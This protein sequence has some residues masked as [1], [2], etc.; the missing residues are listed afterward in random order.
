MRTSVSRNAIVRL[1]ALFFA[2][3]PFFHILSAE[4]PAG[5]T[6]Y[7]QL[8]EWADEAVAKSDWERA[9]TCLQEAMRTEP[10][11]PLNIMLLSNMGM[12]QYYAGE[13]SLALRTLSEARAIAPASTVILTNRARVLTGMGR[14]DD[15]MRDY[16]MVLEMDSTCAD[17]YADR[18]SL[19]TAL[20]R[21]SEAEKDAVKFRSLRPDDPHGA[22]LL[23][24][25][26]SNTNRAA[27]A[28]PL[29]TELIN[30]KP[31]AVYYSARAMCRMLGGEFFEAADD[32][33]RGLELDPED[34][35]L[36][37]SRAY[38]N[39]LRFRDVDRDADAKRAV[40]LGIDPA[41]VKALPSL[42][43]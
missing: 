30:A 42:P 4:E 19:L 31:E 34:G 1:T 35:E 36:Y 3:V 41:R 39:H 27:D 25:I 17:A 18:A 5:G 13:D 37:F 20:N 16:D 12:M 6:Q 38:L 24:V 43:R 40:E 2:V 23:A 29:Y 11:N 15:A 10:S 28:I 21:L 22:L 26:Y 33:A 32:I 14:T 8:V 7:M 9:I